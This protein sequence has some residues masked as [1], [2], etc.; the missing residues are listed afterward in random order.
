MTTPIN[1]AYARIDVATILDLQNRIAELER[2]MP[3]EAISKIRNDTW[4]I[5]KTRFFARAI[6]VPSGSSDVVKV[7]FGT[8]FFNAQPV[9]TATIYDSTS[10][11]K[12]IEDATLTMHDL[13]KNSV[14]ISINRKTKGRII[15]HVIAIGEGP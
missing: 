7:D 6:N 15:I 12:N 13:S 8:G 1:E 2:V 9:V 3:T 4:N 10:K 14:R 11:N 5:K